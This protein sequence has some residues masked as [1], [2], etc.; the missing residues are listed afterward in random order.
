[1][2]D[3]RDRII[4]VTLFSHGCLTVHKKPAKSTRSYL[5]KFQPNQ[6]LVFVNLSSWLWEFP[7][8]QSAGLTAGFSSVSWPDKID[9][10]LWL[11]VLSLEHQHSIVSAIYALCIL[12]TLINYSSKEIGMFRRKARLSPFRLSTCKIQIVIHIS[13]KIMTSKWALDTPSAV[14]AI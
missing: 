13:H 8:T 2:K 5:H 3:D 9:P 6:F 4:P 11:I 1:M 14:S 10:N 12:F 7:S